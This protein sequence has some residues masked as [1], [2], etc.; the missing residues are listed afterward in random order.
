MSTSGGTGSGYASML[1]LRKLATP[2]PSTMHQHHDHEHALTQR[3]ADD[4]VHE[5]LGTAA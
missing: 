2:A 3:E 4:G 5:E 1:S